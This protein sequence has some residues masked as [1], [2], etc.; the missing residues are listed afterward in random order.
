[1][2][3][4]KLVEFN[5]RHIKTK[6]TPLSNQEK[7]FRPPS[8]VSGLAGGAIG[9]LLGKPIINL[10]HAEIRLKEAVTRN[11]GHIYNRLSN[12]LIPSQR[13]G[14]VCGIVAGRLLI[15]L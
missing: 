14:R 11:A 12:I 1:M 10:V 9:L 7:I 4:P 2:N 8:S 15:W 5:T 3:Q 13:L 6:I